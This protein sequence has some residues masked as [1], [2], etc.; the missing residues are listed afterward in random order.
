VLTWG[1]SKLSCVERVARPTSMAA[2]S[3]VW[4]VRLM[5][6][7]SCRS[8]GTPDGRRSLSCRVV[9]RD[10]GEGFLGLP[11]HVRVGGAVLLIVQLSPPPARPG[12]RWRRGAVL[13][14]GEHLL[15]GLAGDSQLPRNVGLGKAF[16]DQAADHVAALGGK[17]PR[18]PRVLQGLGPD[19]LETLESLLVR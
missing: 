11:C 2:R 3:R 5:P 18:Q 15:D 8:A 19:L 4:I 1:F 14:A 9:V 7:V 17:L 16:R 13:S 12:T 10:S 6:V